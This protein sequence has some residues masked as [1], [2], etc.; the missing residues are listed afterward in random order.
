MTAALPP[1]R[2]A[3]PTGLFGRR[4][5]HSFLAK[6]RSHPHHASVS[7]RRPLPRN[8]RS[9]TT[10]LDNPPNANRSNGERQGRDRRSVSENQTTRPRD[11]MSRC[12][13]APVAE[14]SFWRKG[15][16]GG[17]ESRRRRHFSAWNLSRF[18]SRT[19]ASRLRIG[20]KAR[21]RNAMEDE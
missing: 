8:A 18:P 6:L 3:Q 2:Q 4:R 21:D 1:A 14:F 19:S 20:G 13:R 17:K 12:T 7:S 10:S 5:P 15:A 11:V 16:R 9:P